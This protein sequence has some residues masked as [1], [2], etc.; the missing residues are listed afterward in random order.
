MTVWVLSGTLL[1]L[2][3]GAFIAPGIGPMTIQYYVAG[4]IVGAG[5]GFLFDF[6]WSRNYGYGSPEK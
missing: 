2:V 3:L 5:V 4:A 1:G 6:Y